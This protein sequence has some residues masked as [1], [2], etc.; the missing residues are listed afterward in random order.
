MSICTCVSV[1]RARRG[2]RKRGASVAR[3]RTTREK[4]V[5]RRFHAVGVR[6]E[7]LRFVVKMIGR[8]NGT[9]VEDADDSSFMNASTS[10]RCERRERERKAIEALGKVRECAYLSSV[11]PRRAD[12]GGMDGSGDGGTLSSYVEAVGLD[13]S[14]VRAFEEAVAS[15]AGTGAGSEAM[16]G[17][18]LPE[19]KMHDF[20]GYLRR[21][22]EKYAAFVEHRSYAERARGDS[23]ARRQARLARFELDEEVGDLSTVPELFFEDDDAFAL[24]K[25]HV[26]SKACAGIENRGLR[27]LARASTEVQERLGVHLDTIEQHLIREITAK[28]DEFFEALKALSDLHESMSETQ[29]KVSTMVDSMETLGERMV[30]PGQ[31]MKALHDKRENL[32][33]LE[34]TFTSI[35]SL[36]QMRLD[37]DVFVESADYSGALQIAEDIQRILREDEV[38]GKLACFRKLP[39]HVERTVSNVKHAM[40]GDFIKGANVVVDAKSIVSKDQIEHLREVATGCGLEIPAKKVTQGDEL[41]EDAASVLENMIPP[42]IALLYS[43]NGM[44][45]EALT[46]WSQ[47]LGEDTRQVERIATAEILAHVTGDQ[48]YA[49]TSSLEE[50]AFDSAHANPIRNLP[51]ELFAEMIDALSETFKRYFQRTML[52]QSMIRGVIG[53]DEESL[54]TLRAMDESLVSAA[55]EAATD[56]DYSTSQAAL[57]VAKETLNKMI[58][59]AQGRVAKLFGVRAPMNVA[60]ESHEFMRIIKA[61]NGFLEMAESIGKHRCLSLHSTLANQSKAFIRERHVASSAELASLLE[62]ETWTA[63]TLPRNFQELV[64]ALVRDA[65]QLPEIQIDEAGNDT[66]VVVVNDVFRPVKSS[67]LL[68]HM[69]AEYVRLAHRLPSLAT[70][71]THRVLDLIKKYNAGV[72]QLILGAGAMQV[73]KLKSITAKHLCLSQQSISLLSAILP[74]IQE[75]TCKLI[76]GPKHFL[77]TQEFDRLKKDLALHKSE[78][79][80]KLVSIMRDRVS[81]HLQTLSAIVER[82][83]AE[84]GELLEVPAESDFAVALTKEMGTLRRVINE[85]LSE[86]D[87]RDVLGRVRS[88]SAASL[89]SYL[90]SLHVDATSDALLVTQLRVDLDTVNATIHE[91]PVTQ[92]DTATES[93]TALVSELKAME[94]AVPKATQTDEPAKASDEPVA[95]PVEDAKSEEKNADQGEQ[96]REDTKS[97]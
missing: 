81:V 83:R 61:A 74:H 95:S 35:S 88:E 58:D 91:L 62:G 23:S 56:V 28:S 37:M 75:G 48:R 52:V 42:F 22:R 14:L 55:Q 9:G 30:K 38:L 5:G 33:G 79:H 3:R 66:T 45:V 86:D 80:E 73:S 68:V 71:C 85:L 54:K 69:V 57:S 94:I 72:C 46:R 97:D 15:A 36:H 7:S 96:Q 67:L 29:I 63:A 6:V 53:G 93:L 32:R 17:R 89:A 84:R 26:F 27:E 12:G 90:R 51:A 31:L 2:R 13:A 4:G 20:E 78:I 87:C 92:G 43:G 44:L 76:E 39:E 19:V 18:L 10:E 41:I 65:S 40:V 50:A 47:S 21:T 60:L 64:D 25:P 16:A 70:E 24:S 82:S 34:K 8:R 49:S 59:I 11:T 77:L 1:A